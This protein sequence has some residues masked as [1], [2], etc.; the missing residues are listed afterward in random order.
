VD[1]V[2]GAVRA[3]K[4]LPRD[5]SGIVTRIGGREIC[6]SAMLLFAGCLICLR[7]EMNFQ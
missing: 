7:D 4:F 6:R 3:G 1:A 5:S 2:A